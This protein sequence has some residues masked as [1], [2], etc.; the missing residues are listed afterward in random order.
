MFLHKSI[1]LKALRHKKEKVI[2]TAILLPAKVH[3]ALSI[4]TII[5][6][7]RLTPFLKGS[8]TIFSCQFDMGP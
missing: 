7:A 6:K 2:R 8:K 4:E 1:H 3:Q 5:K